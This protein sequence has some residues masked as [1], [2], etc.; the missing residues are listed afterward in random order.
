MAGTIAVNSGLPTITSTVVID[1]T[2]APGYFAG[3]LPVLFLDGTNAGNAFGFDVRADNSGVLAL[4][5]GNFAFHGIFVV[6]RIPVTIQSCA[7]GV[8]LD[9]VTPVPNANSGIQM[10]D[11]VDFCTVGGAVGLGNIIANNSVNCVFI[12]TNDCDNNTIR[13][14]QMY[15]NR[16]GTGSARG[17]GL[18]SGVN[19]GIAMPPVDTFTDTE[20]SGTGVPGAL[21]DLYYDRNPN[22]SSL[23]QSAQGDEYIGTTTV[24]GAGDWLFSG[25]LDTGR[26]LAVHQTDA[27]GNS[28][29]SPI[30]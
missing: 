7:I 18:T 19:D 6:Q 17:I 29:P 30:R 9:G 8:A 21:V 25:S 10:T 4:G 27:A 14:N 22:P 5:I 2:T 1:G 3:G 20:A 24:D 16:P 23:S 12:N 11:D 15:A 26:L 13:F 28:S